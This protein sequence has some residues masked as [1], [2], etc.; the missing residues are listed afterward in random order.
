MCVCV[1]LLR[2]C[3]LV[4]AVS[5]NSLMK[6]I[7]SL[8]GQGRITPGEA[9]VLAQAVQHYFYATGPGVPGGLRP[10]LPVSTFEMSIAHRLVAAT[11]SDRSAGSKRSAGSDRSTGGSACQG[12]MQPDCAEPGMVGGSAC[13]AGPQMTIPLM[14]S[15]VEAC[16]CMFESEYRRDT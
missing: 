3:D 6:L 9:S 5:E 15:V 1:R 8:S 10:D 14:P 7:D 12:G 2:M 11:G 13:Q 16:V 4:Y